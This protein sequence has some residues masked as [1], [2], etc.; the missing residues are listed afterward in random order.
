MATL[1]RTLKDLVESS[2]TPGLQ[3]LRVGPEGVRFQ[4][5]GGSADLAARTPVQQS[6]LFSAYSLTKTF[7]AAAVLRLIDQRKLGLEDP[8]LKYVPESPYGPNV[9]IRHLLAQTSGIPNPIPLKW[10]HLARDH[11]HFDEQAELRSILK[12][13]LS[14][15]LNRE[16]NICIRTSLTGFWG[17]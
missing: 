12:K 15:R 6:S 2:D 14:F 3:Y 13:I 7:T 10:V 8:L 17:V 9:R 5:E 11:A 1:T 16:K 4:Y